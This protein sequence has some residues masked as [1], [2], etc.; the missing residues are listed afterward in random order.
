M[1]KLYLLTLLSAATIMPAAAQSKFDAGSRMIMSQYSVY[2][3][4]PSQTLQLSA[5][6]FDFESASRAGAPVSVIVTLADGASAADLE[7]NGFEI[8]I[9]CGDMVMAR[10]SLDQI[11]AL[12]NLDCVQA[13]SFGEQRQAKLDL[14]RAAVGAEVIQAGTEFST[15]YKGQG[16]ITGIY[17]TGFDANHANFRNNDGSTRIGSLWHFTSGNGV[18]RRYSTPA[19]IA[20]FTTD[21][22][23]ESHGTHTT[24]CMAGSFNRRGG[25]AIA[26][27]SGNGVQAGA[28]FANPYYGIAPEATIAAACGSLYDDNILKGVD[29]IIKYAKSEG[30]PCV[31]NLSIGSTIGPHDGTDASSQM[32]DRLG[33]EAII[34][35]AAGNEGDIP[36]SITKKFTAADNSFSTIFE[37]KNSASGIIDIYSNDSRNFT[38]T[39]FIY[40]KNTGNIVYGLDIKGDS[41][42]EGALTTSNY[43]HSQY[44]HDAMFDRAFTSSSVLF[45]TSNNTTTNKRYSVRLQAKL[46]NNA[47]TNPRGNYVFGFKVKGS[48]GQLIHTTTSSNDAEFT[49]LGKPEFTDGSGSFSISSMACGENVLCVG[50]WNT[51]KK[52]PCV[53]QNNS[54]ASYSY[55]SWGFEVDSVAGYSSWGIL[56]DGRQLPHVCAPGSGIISSI[57]KYNYD[58]IVKSMP[59]YAYQM[60]AN[61]TFN[62]RS[63]QWEA[64]QGTSMATPIVAGSIAL[65]LQ[66]KPDLTIDEVKKIVREYSIKDNFVTGADRPI[67]WGA[68]KF[69]ALS[70]LRYLITGNGGVDDITIDRDSD[71]LARPIGNDTWEIVV[72]GA[73]AV[74]VTLYNTQGQTVASASG[75]DAAVLSTAGLAKGIYIVNANGTHSTRVV[76]R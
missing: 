12:E 36:M 22:A 30:K 39:L 46:A 38:V 69:D 27:T 68:G 66:Y 5:T 10:A 64:M 48:D 62:D 19:E 18:F 59:E 9:D 74:N 52:V 75:S 73:T 43:Q 20:T 65:W 8:V 44:V 35:I 7:A 54:G 71:I 61:Q 17:D 53:G 42:T 60:S 13:V 45:V 14:A 41:E 29:E 11:A 58:N 67:Q 51:R 6:P 31:I 15:A 63:N 21:K 57:S 49:D 1:N 37:G 47:T 50:A 56:A 3:V 40:D 55:T 2:R 33:K 16:V 4:D 76:V 25:G 72:P 23:T 28:R 34:C 24:G 32:L 70:G 26:V